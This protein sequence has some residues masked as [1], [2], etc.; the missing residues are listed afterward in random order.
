M[1]L[2]IDRSPPQMNAIITITDLRC[3]HQICSAL[4]D[5]SDIED[6]LEK[7]PRGD[8]Y[9]Y[10]WEQAI[11]NDMIS[12]RRE[13]YLIQIWDAVNREINFY[14]S[15]IVSLINRLW[16]KNNPVVSLNAYRDK[17]IGF[18]LTESL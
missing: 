3:N 4:I 16:G 12:G 14:D 1:S 17:R 11:E 7:I 10:I 9:N 18:L 2:F 8:I 6:K 5:I 13:D 15:K